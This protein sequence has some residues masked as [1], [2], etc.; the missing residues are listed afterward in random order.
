MLA[1]VWA[2]GVLL[3]RG[4][5]LSA[6]ALI[7]YN[8]LFLTLVVGELI[9][10]SRLR[11]R[12]FASILVSLAVLFALAFCAALLNSVDSFGKI[13]LLTWVVFMHLPLFLVGAA[14]VC[15]K[16]SRAI[17]YLCA[18]P[19][20]CLLLVSLDAFLIEPHWI[21]V[22]R[23][24]IRSNKLQKPVRIA[25]IADLQT[26][27]LQWYEKH[28]FGLVAV[29]RPD[30]ILLAGDYLHMGNRAEY[31]TAKA[32]LNALMRQAHLEAPLGIYAVR[33]NVEWD[34]WAALFA[35]LPIETFGTTSNR[36]LGPVILTGLTLD[37]S[38]NPALSVSA[39]A[40]FHIVIGH[41]PDYSLGK[42]EADL[43]I[44]GHTHGGQF[45]LPLFGPVFTLS[46]IPRSWASGMTTIAPGKHLIVARGI[47]MERG[48]APRLRFL[49]RPELLVV[50]LVPSD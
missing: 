48:N 14:C 38:C 34:D 46:Q 25:V 33:G 26:D 7:V 20:I 45:R 36:D 16:R 21:E 6:N 47:G 18:V 3:D 15:C 35:G 1:V 24:C 41:S 23:I 2:S 44:A 42:I 4:G 28:I 31:V 32:E 9:V 5:Y 50:D 43:L 49:C 11:S 22:T 10:L 37:D 12:Y 29:E 40:K 13:Q 39:Q 17:F 8:A 30:L 19:G 27:K